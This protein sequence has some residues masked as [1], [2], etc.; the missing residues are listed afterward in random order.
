[1]AEHHRFGQRSLDNLA[2]VKPDLQDLAVLALKYSPHDFTI[3]E[4]IRTV[5]RQKQLVA[6]GKS[7]TMNSY[8]LRGDAIDFYPYYNGKV[9]VNAPMQFFREIADAFKKAADKLGMKITW[10]GDWRTFIDGPHIQVE[11]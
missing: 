3:T 9:Q 6:E 11:R 1:M 8:H 2:T 4:G 7:K 10:G 5:E